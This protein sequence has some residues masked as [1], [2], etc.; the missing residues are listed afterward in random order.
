[1]HIIEK[2]SV[3]K[4]LRGYS[5]LFTLVFGIFL[6]T[7]MDAD[8]RQAGSLTPIGGSFQNA[9]S[10]DVTP[11]GTLFIVEKNRHRFL[12][13]DQDGTR[14]DSTGNQGRGNYQFDRPLSVDATNGLKIYIADR[15]NNRVQIFDRRYQFLST[16]SAAQ[17]R[18][19]SAFRPEKIVVNRMGE[20]FVYNSERHLIHKFDS[21]GNYEMSYDLRSNLIGSVDKMTVSQ[22]QLLILEKPTGTLH[23]YNFEGIYESFLGGFA[24]RNAVR[25]FKGSMWAVEPDRL[26]RLSRTGEI[27]AEF[28]FDGSI[29]VSDFVIFRNNAYLLT[30]GSL[31]KMELPGV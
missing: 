14:I 11:R 29:E 30:S 28:R 18:S 16:I 20:L 27:T 10:I 24:N 12:V 23:R 17:I 22:N 3:I 5:F 7:R 9:V 31:F 1:M 19:V 21:N 8:A 25:Y 6:F 2:I 13:L 15:N 4:V 26:L